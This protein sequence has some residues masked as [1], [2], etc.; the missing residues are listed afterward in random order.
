[1]R[2]QLLLRGCG[3]VE[4]VC[5]WGGGSVVR[6]MLARFYRMCG[7]RGRSGVGGVFE[8]GFL[9]CGGGGGGVLGGG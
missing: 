4:M 1:M 5:C 7:E 2:E 6:R 8:W 9:G 3:G